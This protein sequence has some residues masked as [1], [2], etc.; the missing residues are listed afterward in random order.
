[1]LEGT[2]EDFH[3]ADLM[4]LSTKKQLKNIISAIEIFDSNDDYA[5]IVT[6]YYQGGD[7]SK[8]LPKFAKAQTH[9]LEIT[10]RHIMLQ[11]GQGIQELHKQNIIHRDIKP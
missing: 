9:E 3:E 7:L 10:T 11:I 6:K 8:Y 4:K 1:M 2:G 5:Y